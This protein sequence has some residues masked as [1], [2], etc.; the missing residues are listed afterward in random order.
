M[1]F[2]WSLSDN[3]SPQVSRTLLSILAD[4]NTAVVWMVSTRPIISKSSSSNPLATVPSVPITIGITFTFM[5]H[6]FYYSLT[7]SWHLSFFSPFFSFTLRS[8]RKAKSTI[9]QV[10]FFSFSFFFFVVVRSGRLAEIW[11]SVCISKS[12]FVRLVFLNGFWVV[13][14]VKFKIPAQFPVD[15][16]PPLS[17]V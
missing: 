5:F 17:R 16:L 12:Q 4:F 14:L 7:R 1:V 11:W 8:L 3:K 2:H 10:L 15:H 9:R 6:S 13:C